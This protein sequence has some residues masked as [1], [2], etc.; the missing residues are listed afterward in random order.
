MTLSILNEWSWL[1][2]LFSHLMMS[3]SGSGS[4]RWCWVWGGTALI[5]GW[6]PVGCA[7]DF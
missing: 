5:D 3:S 6:V 4:G 7:V 1:G 2:V